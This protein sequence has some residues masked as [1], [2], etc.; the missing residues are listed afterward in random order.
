M[1]QV[2]IIVLVFCIVAVVALKFT[3][4][5]VLYCGHEKQMD[6]S[7]RVATHCCR[8]GAALND[9][10]QIRIAALSF[11]ADFDGKF[12]EEMS[13]LCPDYMDERL[14]DRDYSYSQS[15]EGFVVFSPQ[16]PSVNVSYIMKNDGFVHYSRA[17]DASFLDRVLK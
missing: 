6:W 8:S 16:S 1:K 13:E 9:L 4:E 5:R 17:R 7:F 10:R 2:A 12:P 14:L 15:K 11:A 3:S